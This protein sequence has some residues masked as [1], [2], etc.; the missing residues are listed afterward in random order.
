MSG[1]HTPSTKW[2]IRSIATAGF[3][4][5][6][7]L[8]NPASL[9]KVGPSTKVMGF[10]LRDRNHPETVGAFYFAGI[11][12]GF[13]FGRVST[14]I[15]GWTSFDTE[16]AVTLWD[17][18]GSARLVDLGAG[19]GLGLGAA[20]FTMHG[21]SIDQGSFWQNLFHGDA[22]DLSGVSIGTGLGGG[23]ALGRVALVAYQENSQDGMVP[24]ER[25]VPLFAGLDEILQPADRG[26][27]GP[28]SGDGAVESRD[29]D[30]A[31]R[32]DEDLNLC[33]AEDDGPADSDRPEE[34]KDALGR[35]TNGS[36]VGPENQDD[37]AYLPEDLPV[38]PDLTNNG[39][40]VASQSFN[41]D[42]A[43]D[44][45]VCLPEDDVEPATGSDPSAAERLEDAQ[46]AGV[47]DDDYDYSAPDP[48]EQG[49]NNAG[50]GGA[51]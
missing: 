30:F 47:P 40:N 7:D 13:G 48:L 14:G 25:D 28:S 42:S 29:G 22:I 51:H 12:G 10:E 2:E 6:L 20:S 49:E 44:D 43:E 39:S 24:A 23:V 37:H 19:L 27:D 11:S 41:M 3:S 33:L 18:E 46:S 36:D 1:I 34:K 15:P 16:D 38:A 26:I 8:P 45:N 21:I 17:F 4:G 35:A 50:G 9:F 5:S 32:M 31:G